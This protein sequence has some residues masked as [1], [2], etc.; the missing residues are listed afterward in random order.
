MAGYR[1]CRC[2]LGVEQ[3]T[4]GIFWGPSSQYQVW[5]I[6]TSLVRIRNW[7]YVSMKR[8]SG[9]AWGSRSRSLKHGHH[10]S[11]G[12]SRTS[13]VNKQ[14]VLTPVA[15]FRIRNSRTRLDGLGSGGVNGKAGLSTVVACHR[16]RET[17]HTVC[18]GRWFISELNR[19]SGVEA[20]SGPGIWAGMS[21][22]GFTKYPS[23]FSGSA[24]QTLSTQTKVILISDW[25]PNSVLHLG[26]SA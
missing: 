5:L 19:Q 17:V 25:A 18:H 15:A 10:L 22:N 8:R 2:E 23:S 21:L 12:L 16:K 9:G 13:S 20:P 4:H 7:T 1:W 26:V 11:V 6:Y 14:E 24:R 3:K